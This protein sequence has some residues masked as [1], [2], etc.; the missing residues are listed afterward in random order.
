MATLKDLGDEL[1]NEEL[2]EISSIRFGRL[3]WQRPNYIPSIKDL[4]LVSSRFECL[5]LL[6]Q[7]V[8]F[9]SLVPN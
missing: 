1:T 6:R 5:G 3:P 9:N 8:R 2:Q 4:I 7:G